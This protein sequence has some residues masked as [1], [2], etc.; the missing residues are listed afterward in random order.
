[1]RR[2]WK[3][4]RHCRFQNQP[5]FLQ[6]P[7]IKELRIHVLALV[8]SI[9]PN[10]VM[11]KNEGNATSITTGHFYS[12]CRGNYFFVLSGNGH[13][14]PRGTIQPHKKIAATGSW[15]SI[16][17][18]FNPTGN[19]NTFSLQSIVPLSKGDEIRALLS[20]GQVYNVAK[21]KTISYAYYLKNNW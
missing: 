5:C 12:S 19:N 14:H 20:S 3:T 10:D 9:P 7:T 1:M 11:V 21:I 17:Q 16:G 13:S 4:E 8:A 15:D 6:R 2:F 18:A